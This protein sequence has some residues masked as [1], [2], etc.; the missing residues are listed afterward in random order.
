[1]IKTRFWCWDLVKFFLAHGV[2]NISI[3]EDQSFWDALL[4]CT[5]MWRW[6]VTLQRFVFVEFVLFVYIPSMFFL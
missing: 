3:E 6:G 1:M 5:S 4:G 2:T